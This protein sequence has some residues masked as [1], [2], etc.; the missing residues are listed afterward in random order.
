M[1]WAVGKNKKTF[2]PIKWTPY[3]GETTIDNIKTRI[4]KIGELMKGN[5]Q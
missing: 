4:T 3:A 2:E 1:E 5:A